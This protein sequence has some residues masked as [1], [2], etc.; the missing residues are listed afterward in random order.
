VIT[1]GSVVTYDIGAGVVKGVVLRDEVRGEVVTDSDGPVCVDT[2]MHVDVRGWP[3]YAESVKH[4]RYPDGTP[5][6]ERL[7]SDWDLPPL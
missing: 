2:I 5:Y 3:R 1:K 6:V 4:I 7:I